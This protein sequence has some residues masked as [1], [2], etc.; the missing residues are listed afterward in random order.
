MESSVHAFRL[1]DL[2]V[3]DFLLSDELRTKIAIIIER[4]ISLAK[5]CW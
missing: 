3:L 1:V 5:A 2:F 4:A